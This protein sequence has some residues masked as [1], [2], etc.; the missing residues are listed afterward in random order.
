MA[1]I[2]LIGNLNCDRV[3]RL[4]RPLRPGD[5]IVH[6]MEGD[7]MG[8]AGAITGGALAYAGHDVRIAAALG[9]DA[10]GDW[11]V[12]QAHELGLDTAAVERQDAPTAPVHVMVDPAGER[13][14]LTSADRLV[15]RPPPDLAARPVD[16]LYVNCHGEAVEPFLEAATARTGLVIAQI[17]RQVGERRPAHVLIASQPDL[18]ARSVGLSLEAAR[19]IAGPALR[20]LVVTHGAAGAEAIG[21]G[22]RHSAAAP[23]ADVVD[24]TGAGDVFAAGLIDGLVRGE[25]MPDALAEAA[26]WGAY[27][28]TCPTSIPPPAFRAWLAARA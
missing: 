23:P 13:T 22:E 21:K 8:G 19:M 4:D 7:R 15:Y 27:A 14:I 6:R 17:P 11:I 24:T 3:W 2:L 10:T 9:A 25:T 18:A 26:A 1:R 20:W 5:R 16:A 12:A 28:V